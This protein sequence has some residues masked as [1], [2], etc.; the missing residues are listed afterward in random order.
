M[1]L[2]IVHTYWLGACYCLALQQGKV[3]RQHT[4]SADSSGSQDD[5][6][7]AAPPADT[8]DDL[9]TL[10]CD[11]QLQRA[12]A[13]VCDETHEE[14]RQAVMLGPGLDSRPFRHAPLPRECMQVY[15]FLRCGLT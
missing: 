15:A 11:G 14:C 1:L 3:L 6:T 5:G 12:V 13:L 10:W 4:L 9:V 2:S 7:P 8:W